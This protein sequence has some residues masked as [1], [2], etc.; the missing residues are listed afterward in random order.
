M[1][2]ERLGRGDAA[3]AMHERPGHAAVPG[4]Q[5]RV[6]QDAPMS[7]SMHAA[8][9]AP[10]AAV[11]KTSF[12]APASKHGLALF[13]PASRKGG[14][15]QPAHGDAS[16]SHGAG[17]SNPA[18]G[19]APGPGAPPPVQAVDLLGPDEHYRAIGSPSAAQ[20]VVRRSWLAMQGVAEGERVITVAAHAGVV[21]AV[22]RELRDRI[23]TWADDERLEQVAAN[24]Q[25]GLPVALG[26]MPPQFARPIER[27][28][29]SGFGLRSGAQLVT[30]RRAQGLEIWFD[31]DYLLGLQPRTEGGRSVLRNPGF[32]ASYA[33]AL[34]TEIGA[35]MLPRVRTGLLA[36]PFLFNE[37]LERS[38]HLYFHAVP[39]ATLV[40]AFGGP[41]IAAYR[42]RTAGAQDGEA[43]TA[44]GNVTL[45]AGTPAEDRQLVERELRAIYGDRG[46]ATPTQLTQ[47]DVDALRRFAGDPDRAAMLARLR[48]ARGR[49]GAAS[50]AQTV[51]DVLDTVRQELAIERSPTNVARSGA[52][53]H[54]PVPRP[55][56]GHLRNR[57]G[58]LVP[59]MEAQLD[60][61]EDDAVDRFAVPSVIIHW[62]ARR[63]HDVQRA[64]D[65]QVRHIALAAPVAA[66]SELTHYVATDPQGMLNDRIFNFQVRDP[67]VYDVHAVVEHAFYFPAS[68]T[69][70]GGLEV[71][72]EAS[73]HE[74][75]Q[76]HAFAGL[77]EGAPTS[78]AHD[79]DV[80]RYGDGQLAR[81]ALSRAA[82]AA[83]AGESNTR[84]MVDEI[85][86]L[87][88]LQRQYETSED[89]EARAIVQY[90][91]ERLAHLEDAQRGLG[92]VLGDRANTVVRTWGAYTS[93]TAGVQSAD[94][95]I[96]TWLRG[97]SNGRVEGHLLDH[98]QTWESRNYQ[99]EVTGDQQEAVF[100]ALFV[101]L[102]RSY[103]EGTLTL[104]FEVPGR[105]R[106][107][108]QYTR[109]TDT[110]RR[111]VSNVV[112]SQP[113]A[114][115]VNL[116]AVIVGVFNPLAGMMISVA[117]NSAQTADD[118]TREAAQGT[119]TL[120]H[121]MTSLGLLAIDLL[122]AVGMSSRF[123]QLGRTAYYALEATQLA[124][125]VLLVAPQAAEQ[126]AQLREGRIRDLAR[127]EDTIRTRRANN[128]SDAQLHELEQ[129]AQEMR[130]EVSSIGTRVIAELAARQLI[131]VAGSAVIQNAMRNQLAQ[132]VRGSAIHDVAMI[133]S[134]AQLHV[135][136][137]APLARV[138][139]DAALAALARGERTALAS[140]G[141]ATLPDGFDPRTVAWGLAELPDGDVMIVRG[142]PQR[143]DWTQLPQGVRQLAAVEAGAVHAAE[144]PAPSGQGDGHDGAGGDGH[145]SDGP[146]GGGHEGPGGAGGGGGPG[147]G[148]AGGGAPRRNHV[149]DDPIELAKYRREYPN[150]DAAPGRTLVFRYAGSNDVPLN[151]VTYWQTEAP[152]PDYVAPQQIATTMAA[153]RGVGEVRIDGKAPEATGHSIVVL[154]NAGETQVPGTIVS[155]LGRLGGDGK[156]GAVV[157]GAVPATGLWRD[158]AGRIWDGPT[159]YRGVSAPTRISP[160]SE[161]PPDLG[162]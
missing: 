136:V 144:A 122:P 58:E 138:D 42:G 82:V 35:P 133:A 94:L 55:I 52:A 112:F 132:R 124:G 160:M 79:F 162:D 37:Q 36:A 152:H 53:R 68:F 108:V 155:I 113:M 67:G 143:V 71:L 77:T 88:A 33:Q 5:T 4:R 92:A 156:G 145:G 119:L 104:R 148:G 18:P 130:A 149:I 106:Q 100:E 128:P 80:W 89:G 66:A 98:T 129:Q 15:P 24:A 34:E 23:F 57:S 16:P 114:I 150:I 115:A 153:L 118:L 135:P 120:A 31:R 28:I 65:G 39:E 8:H 125:S 62:V 105:E 103:P 7:M 1:T 95:R 126:I 46:E 111:D 22:M 85:R 116:T 51:E 64:A 141:L 49:G 19:P 69:L 86:Q 90:V 159:L 6:S 47:A 21:R 20:L 121:G 44:D 110:L 25:I 91:R 96:A 59:G 50:P 3:G 137:G 32:M 9:S 60:F 84:A 54:P 123:V 151:G 56:H 30:Y 12:V 102:T 142:G 139:G 40:G 41:A 127:L 131:I 154:H 87:R 38:G 48:A 107:F 93:R 17:G 73:R 75:Q 74:A 10:P 83:P 11:G 29:L 26:E 78:E 81:G 101:A 157:D 147:G 2:R 99:F 14:D 97:L 45:P 134:G 109:V 158:W 161:A 13:A 146:G 140:A 43:V 61:V 63:T 72:P 70:T 76:A 27:T 117:Y